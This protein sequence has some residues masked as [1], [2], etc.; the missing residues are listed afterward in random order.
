MELI[1]YG[2]RIGENDQIS[3]ELYNNS[4]II[5]KWVCNSIRAKYPGD[6]EIKIH[7]KIAN[8]LKFQVTHTVKENL[9]LRLNPNKNTGIIM[10]LTR[11]TKVQVL[12]VGNNELIDGI[13]AN[14][15]KVLTEDGYVGWCFSGYIQNY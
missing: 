2:E 6:Y 15:V 14:W 3:I 8:I 11:G 5:L 12:E 13:S 1:D 10:T 7:Y 9:R 4:E